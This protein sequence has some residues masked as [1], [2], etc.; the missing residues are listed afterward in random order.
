MWKTACVCGCSSRTSLRRA[1][2]TQ[3][4][5][6]EQFT[7]SCLCLN[8]VWRPSYHI[9]FLFQVKHSKKW[10]IL[11]IRHSNWAFE[12]KGYK[13]KMTRLFSP[14]IFFCIKKYRTTDINRWHPVI[15]TKYISTVFCLWLSIDLAK[16]STHPSPYLMTW[17][18]LWPTSQG[19]VSHTNCRSWFNWE[20]RALNW[21]SVRYGFWVLVHQTTVPTRQ[22]SVIHLQQVGAVAVKCFTF[23]P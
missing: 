11:M 13:V 14:N 16:V 23:W 3:I 5:T 15:Y 9:Y 12:L 1:I 18:W 4:L 10:C 17:I 2:L 21:R 8:G 20:S 22:K 6:V 7:N 19:N